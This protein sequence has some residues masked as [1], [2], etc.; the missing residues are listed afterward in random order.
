MGELRRRPQHL[1]QAFTRFEY[2][3]P[4]NS[5]GVER[6]G[7]VQE[8]DPLV[9]VP[10]LFDLIRDGGVQCSG[11]GSHL[12]WS[13]VGCFVGGGVHGVFSFSSVFLPSGEKNRV[14]PGWGAVSGRGIPQAQRDMPR[15]PD[16]KAHAGVTIDRWTSEG[17]KSAVPGTGSTRTRL[18]TC[19]EES[20]EHTFECVRVLRVGV[21][22]WLVVDA[23]LNVRYLIHYG[24]AVNQVTHETL[25][26]YQVINW[27]L[28]RQ[29]RWSRR[30]VVLELRHRETSRTFTIRR[31]TDPAHEVRGGTR[32]PVLPTRVRQT[33]R[34]S[35]WRLR[36]SLRLWSLREP[37]FAGAVLPGFVCL[38]AGRS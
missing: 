30:C 15:K 20:F 2:T 27:V 5:V 24:P 28:E 14:R 6:P 21:D 34:A 10:Q 9:T 13:A 22:D 26:M 17:P 29:D 12:V 1:N 19:A 11:L 37:A 18:P 8:P 16:T 4:A 25:I 33:G 32:V 36:E 38:S 3:N 23:A 31:Q 7:E 35:E